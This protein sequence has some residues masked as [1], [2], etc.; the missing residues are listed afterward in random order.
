MVGIGTGYSGRIRIFF[1]DL[2]FFMG[3]GTGSRSTNPLTRGQI[4]KEMRFQ[5]L[6]SKALEPGF[7]IKRVFLPFMFFFSDGFSIMLAHS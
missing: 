2:D 1:L 6:G 4:I 5:G 7:G 3:V